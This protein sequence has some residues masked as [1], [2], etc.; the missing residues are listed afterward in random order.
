[1]VKYAA[2]TNPNANGAGVVLSRCPGVREQ[3]VACFRKTFLRMSTQ[4][5]CDKAGLLDVILWLQG[6]SDNI[7]MAGTSC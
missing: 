1:M 2:N 3:V 7:C 6:I 4:L 5:L